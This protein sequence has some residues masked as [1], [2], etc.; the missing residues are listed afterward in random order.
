MGKASILIVDDDVSLGKSLSFV[1]KHKGY[2]VTTA[3]GGMDALAKVRESPFDMV[4]MDIKMP[5]MNG[6]ET[7]KRIKK[8]RPETVVVM[9]T[10]YAVE[11]LVQE[12]LQEGAYGIIYKPLDIEKVIALIEK[13]RSAEQGVLILIVDDDLGTC[14][15]LKNILSKKGYRVGT[16]HNGEEAI[17]CAQKKDYDIIF[18]DMK[19]PTINGLETYL[20]LKKI[21]PEA[22]VI[23]MT[24]YRQELTALVE[25]AL[26]N[27]AYACLNKPFDVEKMLRLIE[28]IQERKSKSEYEGEKW[29]RKRA[30]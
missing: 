6:V 13:A 27:D 26:N 28:E 24:A 30:S 19:L 15:T 10:G 7:Y 14:T 8:V 20:A 21:N 29:N 12:A 18:I 23:I 3:Q 25:E 5:V 1:L 9:M 4:F 2:A 22:V 17:A 16:V 11:D